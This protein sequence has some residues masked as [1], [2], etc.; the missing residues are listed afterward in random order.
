[1]MEI[2]S[3][4]DLERYRIERA[5]QSLVE[6]EDNAKMGH[7][8]LVANRLYY[9]LF[10]MS[11]A[12]LLDKGIEARSHAGVIARVGQHL[13]LPGLLSREDARLISVLQNMRHQGDYDD[14][15]DWT[16]AD[17]APMFKPTKELLDKMKSIMTLV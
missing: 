15:N 11:S 7:W 2:R 12:L 9:A 13:V 1:M 6:A 17:V 8:T 14:F 16:E 3:K 4:Q 5:Y 10:Y